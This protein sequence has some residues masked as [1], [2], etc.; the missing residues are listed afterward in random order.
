M[1][2]VGAD[3]RVFCPFLVHPQ[4][5]D[6]FTDA[7]LKSSTVE[8]SCGYR[9]REPIL[10]MNIPVVCTV[11]EKAVSTMRTNNKYA[12]AKS[13]IT[14][15]SYREKSVVQS[16]ALPSDVVIVSGAGPWCNNRHN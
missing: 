3:G 8:Y 16:V 11:S 5:E 15:I 14:N 6:I 10:L 12:F 9:N 2:D 7:V 1:C 4:T 13:R